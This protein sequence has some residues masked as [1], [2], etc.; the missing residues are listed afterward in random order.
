MNAQWSRIVG[1]KVFPL[2]EHHRE[3]FGQPEVLRDANRLK[4]GCIDDIPS[5]DRAAARV[6]ALMAPSHPRG[7]QAER[8]APTLG[9]S[10]SSS[11]TCFGSTEPV[12]GK[13][14]LAH[15]TCARFDLLGCSGVHHFD[16]HAVLVCT[17]LQFVETSKF[18][19]VAG[20]HG[21][22]QR[23]EDAVLLAPRLHEHIAFAAQACLQAVGG[24]VKAGIQHA[25][26]SSAAW[27]LNF[28]PCR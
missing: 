13:A 2:E 21:L 4:A 17:A 16:R 9:L 3:A 11:M 14:R 25:A 10:P 27:W 20:H 18:V 15:G 1:V 22:P 7:V 12:L 23:R 5:A 19:I 24:V 6:F 26:V 28:S 8:D